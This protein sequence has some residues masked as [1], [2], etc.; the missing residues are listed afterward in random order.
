MEIKQNIL[1]IIEEGEI[2]GNLFFLPNK[3]LERQTYL[4]V[5]KVLENIGGKWNRK[6]KAHVFES[7][8]SDSIDDILLTGNVIDKKKEFQFFETPKNIVSQLI[9]LAEIKPGN[10]CLEP[11]A[12]QGNIAEEIRE[13]VGKNIT[14]IEIMPEN[15]FILENKGFEVYKSDFLQYPL[16]EKFDRIIMNPPFTKQQDIS[17]V[18]KALMHLKDNGILVSVMSAGIK[19]RSNKKTIT[20]LSKLNEYNYDIIEL[21]PGSFKISGTMV[22]TIILKINPR[23]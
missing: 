4:E 16:D 19:F 14:C 22:N 13:I 3:Q 2:N 20:F 21:P 8:I 10:I 12:G 15:V 7:D 5:N 11:S 9:E 23:I 6:F 18:E 1:D 17:H